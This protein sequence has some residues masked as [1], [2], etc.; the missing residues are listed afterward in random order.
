[1]TPAADMRST[2]TVLLIIVLT[3]G[4]L[5]PPGAVAQGTPDPSAAPSRD[6][7]LEPN[8][9]NP[10]NPDTWIP[11]VLEP[12]L[13]QQTDSAVVSIL[14]Y[15]VLA[16]PVAIPLAVDFE[17]GRDPPLQAL[18]YREAGRKLAYWDGKDRNGRTVPAGVY[19]CR[20]VVND[21]PQ[22]ARIIVNPPRRRRR[23]IPWF[24]D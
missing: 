1:M 5:S 2:P 21:Q 24:G 22:L 13:F 7:R 17:G 6:F 9:P 20:L 11:F 4:L 8:R 14:I 15:N 3:F 12:S 16:Q 18:V 23:L 10:A 19:Y